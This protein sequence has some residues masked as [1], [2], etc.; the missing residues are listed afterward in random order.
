MFSK[1]DTI[2]NEISR[3][4]AFNKIIYLYRYY[5]DIPVCIGV[6]IFLIY[7]WR[8]EKVKHLRLTLQYIK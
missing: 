1:Q 7:G 6:Y 2:A 4:F 3:Q 5:I 8:S